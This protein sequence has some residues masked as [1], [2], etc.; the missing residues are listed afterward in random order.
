MMKGK[1]MR[2]PLQPKGNLTAG[3]DVGVDN[4]MAIYVENG[5]TKLVN[6]RPLKAISHYWRKKIA[7][8]QSTLNGYGLRTP[9]KLRQMYMK[10]RRQIKHYIDTKVRGP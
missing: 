6:G 7:K 10:W 4:L 2:V 1:W 3:I 8:Y 5:L 9:R